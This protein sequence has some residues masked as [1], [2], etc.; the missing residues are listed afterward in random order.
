MKLDTTKSKQ[1]SAEQSQGKQFTKTRE[2][3]NSALFFSNASDLMNHM[4]GTTN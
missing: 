2:D 1:S 3:L 4:P